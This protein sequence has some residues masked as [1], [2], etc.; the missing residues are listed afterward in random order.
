LIA[1]LELD[2]CLCWQEQKPELGATVGGRDWG[3]TQRKNSPLDE[4]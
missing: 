4:S 3:A 1:I 2:A